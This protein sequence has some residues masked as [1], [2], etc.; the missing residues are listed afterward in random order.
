V[1]LRWLLI[2]G[3]VGVAIGAAVACLGATR[4]ITCDDHSFEAAC[5]SPD[6]LIA[7]LWGVPIGLVVGLLA[8]LVVSQRRGVER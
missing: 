3:A 7:L 2:G 8:G 4:P 6:V 1:R 5:A